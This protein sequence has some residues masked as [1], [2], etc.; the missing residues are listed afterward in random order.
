MGYKDDQ[1]FRLSSPESGEANFVYKAADNPDFIYPSN[2]VRTSG[3]NGALRTTTLKRGYIRS[4]LTES[5]GVSIPVTKCQF[6]FNPQF[7]TQ[8]VAQTSGL[9]NFFQQDPGQ[10][11]QPVPSAVNFEF[12]ILF[13]RTM[14]VANQQGGV[15]VGD[16]DNPW[17]SAAVGQV[18]VL[19]DIDTLYTVIGQ[20]L[21]GKTATEGYLQKIYGEYVIADETAQANPETGGVLASVQA[22]ADKSLSKIPDF[23]KSNVGNTAFLLP[24]PVRVV[25]S[26]LY[27]VEGLV[28]N[29]TVVYTKFSSSMVPIQAQVSVSMEGKYIGFA[30]KD[31]FLSLNLENRRIGERRGIEAAADARRS[32]YAALAAT[33]GNVEMT[34]DILPPN[35]NPSVKPSNWTASPDPVKEIL[36]FVGKTYNLFARFPG[37]ATETNDKV[38]GLFEGSDPITMAC[39]GAIDVYGPFDP[40]ELPSLSKVEEKARPSNLLLSAG[41]FLDDDSNTQINTK[42]DWRK[43]VKQMISPNLRTTSGWSTE[44][45]MGPDVPL[46]DPSTKHFAVRYKFSC[47]VFQGGV[48]TPGR[49]ETWVLLKGLNDTTTFS[50]VVN[51]SWPQFIPSEVEA[52]IIGGTTV[53]SGSVP[54]DNAATDTR[55]PGQTAPNRPGTVARGSNTPI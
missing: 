3:V 13:D 25:F 6:Q 19:K 30:K 45:T 48:S 15:G 22:D 27:I 18:G 31:A 43:A 39:T 55:R 46:Y 28:T 7:L 35:N 47:T 9:L 21:S 23:L 41:L 24:L 1:F 54:P 37:A 33:A 44:V 11:A 40:L 38:T 17:S 50:K 42:E 34:L 16:V 5:E 26:S 14:E 20:G 52:A 2:I 10:F 8:S 36:K 32:L 4:L 53:P 12:S 29:C 51:I 49:G